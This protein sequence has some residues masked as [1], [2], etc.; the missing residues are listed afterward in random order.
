MRPKSQFFE[1]LSRINNPLT[2]PFKKESEGA[3]NQ[4]QELRDITTDCT[5]VLGIFIFIFIF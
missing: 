3:N 4:Y 5:D 2:G 1:K